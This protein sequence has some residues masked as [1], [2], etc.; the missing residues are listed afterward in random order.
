[1]AGQSLSWKIPERIGRLEELVNNLWWSWHAEA[2]ELFRNID[3]ILWRYRGYNPVRQLREISPERLQQLASDSRFLALYDSVMAAFD[4]DMS[5]ENTWFASHYPDLLKGPV[6]YLSMEFAIHSSLPIYAGG[7]GILAGDTCKEA[8]DLGLP[9]VGVGFMYPQ[10][11]FHQRISASGAQEE[12][13][14]QLDFDEVP[15]QPVLAGDGKRL[16]VKVPLGDSTISVAVWRVGVGRGER[17]S[18]GHG[19]TREHA[20]RAAVVGPSL[21]G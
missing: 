4:A 13:Y 10:G 16:L 17:V 14:Q 8:S 11:Y 3:Y 19:C 5:A 9:F 1:M 6:A 20:A 21:C 12:V 7:L 15:I 2:R 18:A